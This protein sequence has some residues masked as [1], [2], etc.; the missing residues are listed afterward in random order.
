[1]AETGSTLRVK[2]EAI[3]T[4]IPRL[5]D[6]GILLVGDSTTQSLVY[7]VH[8]TLESIPFLQNVPL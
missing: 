5:L 4:S 8:C 6:S 3:L 2:F 7:P 1:M